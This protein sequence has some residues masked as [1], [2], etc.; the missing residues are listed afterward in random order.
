MKRKFCVVFGFA[1][2]PLLVV[3][4]S[5]LAQDTHQSLQFLLDNDP[6]DPAVPQMSAPTPVPDPFA[7]GGVHTPVNRDV[8]SS[9]DRHNST[10]TEWLVKTGQTASQVTNTINLGYRIV[11]I[12]VDAVSP[13]HLFT[14]TYVA[15]SGSYLKSWWWYY[16]VDGTTLGNALSTNNARLISLKAYEIGPG[17]TR[18]TAVM[19]SNTGDDAMSWW[20][21][22]NATTTDITNLIIANQARLTQINAYQTG[23]LK[24]YAVVMV[25]N[26]GDNATG[27]W[28]YYNVTPATVATAVQNNSARLIDLDLDPVTGNL[29]TVMYHCT[30]GCP[31]WWWYFGLT[32]DQMLHISDQNGARIIDVN[33]YSG[34]GDKCYN[35]LHINNSNELTTRVGEILL[36]G[37]DGS[38]GLYLK[39][40]GGSVLAS[41]MPSYPFEP[42][43]TLK[44]AVHYLTIRE[45]Q[46]DSTINMSTL[47]PQYEPPPP[48]SSCPGNTVIGSETIQTADIEMMWHSDN[49]RTR[50]LVD[51]FGVADLNSMMTAINMVDSSVNHV[52]GCGGPTPNQTTLHDL[53]TL[54]RRVDAG[55]DLGPGYVEL[56]Y[57]NMA[58]S[59]QLASEGYD[60]THLVD[61]DIP[62]IID[63]EAPAG[64]SN[65]MKEQ[66]GDQIFLAYKAGG[67]KICTSAGCATYVDHLSIFGYASIPFCDGGGTREYA[68][69]VF[70]NDSTSDSDSEATFTATKAE[71]LREQIRDGLASCFIFADGF[72]SGNDSAWSNTVGS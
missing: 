28:W 17:Q 8:S 18:F 5:G 51:Y 32:E 29:N 6:R 37:T 68:F 58:G 64:M 61:T 1:L 14:A 36:N 20:W 22:F 33:S 31:F 65:T 30:S 27:W 72:E 39:R 38:K 56:F 54:Y 41:L 50:E 3:A 15:N 67:Y 26:T 70:I 23:G 42:A 21:Y 43:S 63:D 71:L 66:F 55:T 59:P 49:T 11:D 45:V 35:F 62:M 48:G 57:G 19:I 69:G 25:D 24:R 13:S 44:A 16:G 10:P 12:E 52:F 9:D 2:L 60:W 47:I 34:C 40:Y 7:R 4:P 53:A 46:D